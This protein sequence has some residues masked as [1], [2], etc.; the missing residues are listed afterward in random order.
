ML[1]LRLLHS[2][3]P[4]SLRWWQLSKKGA[5]WWILDR[6]LRPEC[7]KVNSQRKEWEQNFESSSFHFLQIF[8]QGPLG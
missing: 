6:N 8:P 2:I 3:E 4:L 7:E 1:H 5:R